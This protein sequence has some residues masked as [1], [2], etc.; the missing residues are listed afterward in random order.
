M[1][2]CLCLEGVYVKCSVGSSTTQVD[3]RELICNEDVSKDAKAGPTRLLVHSLFSW[4]VGSP[5]TAKVRLR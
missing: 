3:L 5:L 2:H 4:V 1:I